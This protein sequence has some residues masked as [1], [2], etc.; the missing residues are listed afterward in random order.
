[1][2][3]FLKPYLLPAFGVVAVI[4]L[5]YIGLLKWEISGLEK[6]NKE[7]KSEKEQLQVDL[8]ASENQIQALAERETQ[9]KL[10][11]ANYE[12]LRAE[13]KNKKNGPVADV[14][15]FAI[16]ADIVQ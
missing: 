11:E 8:T 12:K 3:A 1:M 15:R 2:I 7:L 13:L 4:I 6:D 9:N 5:V 14:L 16:D 10:I